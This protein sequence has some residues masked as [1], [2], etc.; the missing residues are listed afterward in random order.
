MVAASFT[1]SVIIFTEDGIDVAPSSKYNPRMVELLTVAN[2]RGKTA[3]HHGGLPVFD[4]EEPHYYLDAEE[5]RFFDLVLRMQFTSARSD[6]I[7]N[8][9]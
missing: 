9:W 6:V 5:S 8:A 2:R 3:P 7:S 1:S 4:P